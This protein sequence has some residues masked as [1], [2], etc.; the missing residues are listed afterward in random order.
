VVD[1]GGLLTPGDINAINAALEVVRTKADIWGAVYM[2]RDLNGESIE[3]LAE[4][5]FRAWKLGAEGR[6]NGLL[7]VIAT[8]DRASRFEVGYGL[9]GELPD[10]HAR[11]ALDHVLAPQMR[12]G[13]VRAAIIQS[14]NYLAGIRSADP[15]FKSTNVD[16][17]DATES[18]GLS[19]GDL[20]YASKRGITGILVYLFCIWIF[21]ALAP[22]AATRLARR[23]AASYADYQVESDTSL[24]KGNHTFWKLLFSNLG[25]KLFL[26]VNPG[27]FVFF[28]C[29]AHNLGLLLTVVVAALICFIQYRVKTD[30]YRS[31][32]Q[33]QRA[34]AE[35]QAA[36]TSSGS[37][38]SSSGSSSGWSSASSRSSSSSSR[39]SS[40]G[41]RSGGGGASSRW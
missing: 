20:S 18:N 32:S 22:L 19:F 34:F 37:R 14:F 6:D 16:G 5:A 40:G 35:E 41:G 36:R 21:T 1:P 30:K 28:A 11:R 39:S 3:S 17:V 4:R 33:Y 27:V 25:S 23:L 31:V 9:E 24:D 8:N 38:S 12:A 13:D 10:V 15:V 29:Y 7:L 26:T 2:V